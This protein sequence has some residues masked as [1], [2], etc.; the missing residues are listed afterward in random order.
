LLCNHS[1]SY[2]DAHTEVGYLSNTQRIV[3]EYKKAQQWLYER[4][5]YRGAKIF[6]LP[7]G[8][9]SAAW[10]KEFAPLTDAIWSVSNRWNTGY[11]TVI[12]QN[13]AKF[14][15]GI[16]ADTTTRTEQQMK[17]LI[18]LAI[19]NN[20]L[21]CFYL[22]GTTE[23]DSKFKNVVD[24]SKTKQDAGLLDIVTPEDFIKIDS[25]DQPLEIKSITSQTLHYDDV[26]DDG[27]ASGHIDF[28]TDL[29]A[30]SIPVAW[31]ATIVTGFTGDDS[32]VVE[33][34][35][36]GDTDRFSGDV[37]QSVYASGY[38]GSVSSGN[39]LAGFG[40]TITPRVTITSADDF[41]SVS[42]G[43]MTVTIYYWQ[44]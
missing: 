14:F 26:I 13:D 11:P 41:S 7:G 1:T 12:P 31:K 8:K 30:F 37:S 38:I 34:G 16:I 2:H 36:D 22:H 5:L 18:D 10:N 39:S 15:G 40:D 29:P 4:K 42:A 3:S 21:I 43:E 33:V 32:A 20:G 17:D 19:A 9:W 24:Y 35:I 23:D 44:A 27:G 6:M 28:S 25:P